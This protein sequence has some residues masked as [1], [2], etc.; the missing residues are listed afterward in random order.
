MLEQVLADAAAGGL[1]ALLLSAAALAVVRGRLGPRLGAV[2]AVVLVAAD[3][4]RAGAG[5]NPMVPASFFGVSA[6]LSAA[7]PSLREGRVFTCSLEESP[8]YQATRLARGR[9]H[10][11][12]TFS[13]LRETLTPFSNL[14]SG[15]ATALSPDLT[16]LVAEEQVLS[17]E[18]ASCRDLDRIVPR[19]QRAGVR[20][21]LSATALHHPD[22][23]LD[24]TLA[25]ARV[26]PLRVRVY[27]TR[28]PSPLLEVAARTP[29][30]DASPG[31]VVEARRSTGHIRAVVES[32]RP[33]TLVVREGWARGWEAR[34]DGR[35]V[36]PGRV[37]GG[38]T[39]PVP[40]GRSAVELR[41]RPPR[42]LA[43]LGL[44]A[45]GLAATAGLL[46]PRRRPPG[47]ASA[48]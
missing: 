18:E 11:L 24:R 14:R 23:V 43:S 19:L 26:A 17:P 44:S 46:R 9:D 38:W 3:L 32:D 2:L 6:E 8:E 30:G 16:M 1:V 10:E 22:L 45:L 33:A 27:A 5:L 42:L 35:T 21:V 29:D 15:V 47:R 28:R 25:P 41:F 40:P 48:A 37:P 13:G 31:R 4:L 36:A 20:W 7:L 12:W 39:V 34:V